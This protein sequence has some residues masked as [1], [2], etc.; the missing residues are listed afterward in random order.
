M[1]AR[2]S[3]RQASDAI[4]RRVRLHIATS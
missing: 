4:H 2:A 3:F 1:P